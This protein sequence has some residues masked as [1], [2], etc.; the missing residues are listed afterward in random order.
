M[1]H[2]F[3]RKVCLQKKCIGF[4]SKKKAIAKAVIVDL[5]SILQKRQLM[6]NTNDRR[7]NAKR[8]EFDYP[9]GGEDI[10]KAFNQSKLDPKMEG[11]YPITQVH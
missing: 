9:V 8:R 5:L 10:L 11:P 4:H 7:L 2:V 6:I 3:I 1:I